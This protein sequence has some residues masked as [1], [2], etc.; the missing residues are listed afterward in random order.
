MSGTEKKGVGLTE[1]YGK[2]WANNTSYGSGATNETDGSNNMN[3][4]KNQANFQTNYPAFYWADTY[5]A[6]GFTSGWYIPA[7]DELTALMGQKDTV[8]SQITKI[9]GSATKF[10]PHAGSVYDPIPSHDYWTSTQC[11]S[12]TAHIS[13][14]SDASYHQIKN[15]ENC[16]TRAIRKF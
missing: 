9:G 1:D 8:N 12:D 6:S 11:Y 10:E 15:S 3:Y 14:S 5:T 7:K 16:Y 13:G 2:K 4:I